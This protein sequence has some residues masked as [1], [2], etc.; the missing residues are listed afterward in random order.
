M[1]RTQKPNIRRISFKKDCY[2]QLESYLQESEISLA[3]KEFL[4]DLAAFVDFLEKENYIGAHY[5]GSVMVE[6]LRNFLP[7]WEK[8]AHSHV[9]KDYEIPIT[10]LNPNA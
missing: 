7:T 9:P 6:K 4:L 5:L 10:E 2:E 8:A 3:K 1:A